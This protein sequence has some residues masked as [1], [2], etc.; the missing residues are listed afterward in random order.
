MDPISGEHART[1]PLCDRGRSEQTLIRYFGF[2][3]VSHPRATRVRALLHTNR[4][5][6]SQRGSKERRRWWQRLACRPL[7][8]GRDRVDSGPCAGSEQYLLGACN[9]PSHV[10]AMSVSCRY[11]VFR[12][13]ANDAYKLP[14]MSSPRVTSSRLTL[15][16]SRSYT[17]AFTYL[18]IKNTGY[19]RKLYGL[20]GIGRLRDGLI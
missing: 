2:M 11:K 20:V 4:A 18:H 8:R 9:E 7:W 1:T 12:L 10:P 17:V 15:P 5:A 13:F 3:Q 16:R 6:R 14:A 19:S